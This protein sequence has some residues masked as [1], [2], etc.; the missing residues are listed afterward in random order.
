MAEHPAMPFWT[1][2]Y[3]GDTK[4]L[5]TTEHGAYLLLLISMWRNDGY[6]PDDDRILARYAGVTAGQWKRMAPIIRPFL[7]SVGGKV[8]QGRLMDELSA[9]RQYSGKQS[10]RAKGRWKGKAL[11][12]N[13]VEDAAA[14]P[15]DA[16]GISRND[17][18]TM[19]PLTPYPL[20]LES[21][22]TTTSTLNTAR[23]TN[24][25]QPGG[26]SGS[27]C[28]GE[29][30]PEGRQIDDDL[31]DRLKAAIG[32]TAWADGSTLGKPADRRE[33]WAWLHGLLL[34]PDE[35]IEVIRE[36]MAGH[37]N[38]P[39]AN[40]A[41]FTPAMRRAAKRPDHA[42]RDTPQPR[43]V[44]TLVDVGAIARAEMARLAA[45]QEGNPDA[46]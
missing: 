37:V 40:F 32:P 21:P 33:A 6:L 26:G 13:E 24:E 43:H 15:R 23:A 20:P 28:A 42:P 7:R 16:S 19:P 41:Y 30:N 38:G 10:D 18:E 14:Q 46:N 4:H 31:T 2:A 11:K 34:T 17:A 8:T 12:T 39:P 3:I 44:E 35:Q 27:G 45:A 1:D 9:V 36:V 22:L 25:P 29:F 5:T